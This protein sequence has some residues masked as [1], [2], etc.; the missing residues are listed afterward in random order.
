MK[1]LVLGGS[2]LL[3][4]ALGVELERTGHQL[5][6]PSHSHLDIT[7]QEKVFDYVRQAQPEIIINCAGFTRVDD[8]ESHQKLA[9]EIN[10]K[11]AGNLAEAS[12]QVGALMVQISTDYIFNGEKPGEYT[13]KDEPAPLSIYGKSKL[14][15][16]ILVKEQAEHWLIIRTSWL[17]GEGGKNF[18]SK[19]LSRWREGAEQLKVVADEKGKPTYARDLARVIKASIEKGLR[20]IYHFANQGVVSWY[21]LAEEVFKLIKETAR[22]VPVRAEEYGL[23]ARRPKNSALSTEKIQKALGIK[24]RHHQLAVKEYLEKTGWIR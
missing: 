23:P 16:E 10:A 8:C 9:F 20:G 7:E 19:I 14:E 1:I 2:G 5:L 22:L 4:S 12:R 15:G 17:F 18:I 24:I 3:G 6:A 11:G 13:E 21:Q